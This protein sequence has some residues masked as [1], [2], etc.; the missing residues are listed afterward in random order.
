MN[1]KNYQNQIKNKRKQERERL[2]KAKLQ[3]QKLE[4]I[5][6]KKIK[7]QEKM[8]NNQQYQEFDR[9][10][11]DLKNAYYPLKYRQI[12]IKNYDNQD[13]EIAGFLSNNFISHLKIYN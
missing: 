10:F 3:K 11:I 1:I 8:L 7:S 13:I 6:K 5:A 9:K 2:Q 4:K 12:N